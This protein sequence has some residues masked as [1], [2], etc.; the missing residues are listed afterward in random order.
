[1]TEAELL[2][3]IMEGAE[4]LA[5]LPSADQE[6]ALARFK[7]SAVQIAELCGLTDREGRR[8]AEELA[9]VLSAML[10][11]EAPPHVLH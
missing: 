3:M 6:R 8:L 1:M 2:S 4:R 5:S 10:P 11:R 7:V 9:S